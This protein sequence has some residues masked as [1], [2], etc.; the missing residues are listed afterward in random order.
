MALNTQTVCHLMHITYALHANLPFSQ[1]LRQQLLI[2]ESKR[3]EVVK[4]NIQECLELATP[5]P[6]AASLLVGLL[7][8]PLASGCLCGFLHVSQ[9]THC[10][11]RQYVTGL[12]MTHKQK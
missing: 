12:V 6:S 4:A 7:A 8:P 10:V 3:A 2:S 11:Q 1:G 5:G 9:D